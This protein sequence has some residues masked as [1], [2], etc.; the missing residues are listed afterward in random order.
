MKLTKT[1]DSV[2][3][4]QQ[5][6]GTEEHVKWH[7]GESMMKIQIVKIS[8]AQFLNLSTADVLGHIIL[9]C[10][11]LSVYCGLF[12]RTLRLYPLDVSSTSEQ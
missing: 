6:Q 9:C 11:G 10:E 4:L 2:N 7:Y 1:R 5:T 12:S 3:K 8:I